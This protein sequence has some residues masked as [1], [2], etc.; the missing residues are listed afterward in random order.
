MMNKCNLKKYQV[1]LDLI[2]YYFL[3]NMN[4][5][6]I[7]CRRILLIATIKIAILAATVLKKSKLIQLRWAAAT[8]LRLQPEFWLRKL[9]VN[10]ECW[11]DFKK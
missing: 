9:S 1:L 6:E 10:A 5:V 7:K 11:D 8:P 2:V 4:D 3:L